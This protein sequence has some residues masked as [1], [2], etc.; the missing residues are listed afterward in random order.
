MYIW[1]V[2]HQI[3]NLDRYTRVDVVE[4]RPNLHT[5]SAFS[6]PKDSPTDPYGT[7]IARFNNEADARYARCLL[8]KSL[9]GHAGAWDAN[10]IPLLSDEWQIVK[11]HFK[12]A[13]DVWDLLRH[14]EI[15]VTGLEEV[16]ILYSRKCE[17]QLPNSLP[18][19]KKE[20]KEK[21]DEQLSIDIKWKPS[22]DIEW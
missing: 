16:T 13:P 12:H 9:M 2:D 14:S 21:L 10:A 1:T 3:L 15:S 8:F 5:L 18:N 7:L 19:S 11:D 20:V 6:T 17:S 22:D 4:R